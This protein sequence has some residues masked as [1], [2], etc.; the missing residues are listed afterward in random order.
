MLIKNDEKSLAMTSI[1][2]YNFFFYIESLKI[3]SFF[4]HRGVK[5]FLFNLKTT[6]SFFAQIQ[7]KKV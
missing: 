4:F 2:Y 6:W 7:K 1:H 5:H 3:T